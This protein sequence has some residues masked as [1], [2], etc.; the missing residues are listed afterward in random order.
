MRHLLARIGLVVLAVAVLNISVATLP[1][2]GG[3][4]RQ[5]LVAGK[6]GALPDRSAVGAAGGIWVDQIT[7]I[8]LAVVRS[9]DPDFLTRVRSAGSVALASPDFEAVI[10]ETGLDAQAEADL[11]AA[12]AAL[13]SED[14]QATGDPF[15]NLQWAHRAMG[16]DQAQA[17]GFMGNGVTVAVVDTGIDCLHEDLRDNC[18]SHDKSKSFVPLPDGSGFEDPWDATNPHGTQVAGIIAATANNGK[19]VRGVAPGAKLISVKVSPASGEGFPWSRLAMAYDWASSHSEDGRRADL[20]NSSNVVTLRKDDPLGSWENVSDFLGIANRLTALVYRRG[21]AIFAAAGNDSI[22]VAAA[23]DLK[24]WP[25]DNAP[26]V[27]TIGAT[28]P[29]GAALNGNVLDDYYDNLASYSNYGFDQYE[30]RF[31]VF[32]GGDNQCNRT[33]VCRVGALTLLCRQ[34]D[35]IATTT[36]RGA[37]LNGYSF[38]M[39]TSASTPHAT[40]LAALILSRYP[41]MG[42]G[43]LVD[44]ILNT[45][46]DLGDPGYDRFFGYGRGSASWLE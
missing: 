24:L 23:N 17:N 12:A 10:P 34:F 13:P 4:E 31:L 1:A 40:G 46:T 41:D 21:V 19:G 5:Y 14:L 22:D 2:H 11:A 43:V 16:V 35:Q 9:S 33:S 25:A 37:G 6:N 36:R 8:G 45:A 20:I 27:V 26:R 39:G 30:N 18:L 29:C 38:F 7:S 44:S 15:Y 3:D 42:V 32:P 28:T